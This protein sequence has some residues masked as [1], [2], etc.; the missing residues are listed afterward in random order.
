MDFL[1]F[2]ENY[3]KED[4]S[5]VKKILERNKSKEDTLI[6]EAFKGKFPSVREA[7]F[8]L[9]TI[10]TS[11]E[12]TVNGVDVRYV[13]EHYDS[14]KTKIS[15][16]N[17]GDIKIIIHNHELPKSNSVEYE[18]ESATPKRRRGRPSKAT[19]VVL[20]NDMDNSVSEE[21]DVIVTDNDSMINDDEE[22]LDPKDELVA[23][24]E[25]LNLTDDELKKAV[26]M[27]EKGGYEGATDRL[28]RAATIIAQMK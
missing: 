23:E 10:A 9:E 20:G 14:L 24:L 27:S 15:S 17:E 13:K 22:I 26:V 12:K 28:S 3:E 16:L 5:Q 2:L 21:D 1:T 4:V 8:N 19:A 18:D 11:S 25:S 7:L 6:K